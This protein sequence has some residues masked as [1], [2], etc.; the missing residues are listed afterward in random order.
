MKVLLA[1]LARNA[2]EAVGSMGNDTPLAVLS[3]RKPLLYSYFKQLFAQVTNPPIDSIR[4]A[5]VMSVQASVGSEHNLL[6]ETPEHA[7]QLVIDNPILRDEELERL[8]RVESTVFRSHTVDITW[9]VADGGEGLAPALERMCADADAALAAGT[10]IL[11]LSDRTASPE[12]VP[13]PSLLATSALHHHLV[14]AGTRLQTGIV[15]ESGEP[16]SVHSIAVLI[17]YGAAAVNPY[18]ML[19]T[20]A[21]LV[22]L[23]WLPDGM[24]VEEA[25]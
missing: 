6:V 18:V 24:T 4:E 9:P 15:V 1:P 5:V 23:G 21:E 3:N 19:E 13:I 14:R 7:R 17:G 11:I 20:L 16:R 10:N 22:D 25:Q 8:R 12:R 2:E